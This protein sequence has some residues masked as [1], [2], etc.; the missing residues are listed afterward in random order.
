VV[1][2]SGSAT[3]ETPGTPAAAKATAAKAADDLGGQTIGSGESHRISKGDVIIVPP[4]VQHSYKNIEEPF[5]YLV[6]QTP[7]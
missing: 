3:F 2:M 5:R 6:V 4:G 1:V 7:L